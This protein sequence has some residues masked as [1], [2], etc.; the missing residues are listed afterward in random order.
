[1]KARPYKHDGNGTYTPCPPD[2]ATHI[3]LRFPGPFTNRMI[4]VTT[5]DK[6]PDM[7]QWNGQTLTPTL[8]PSIRSRI[9]DAVCHS[10][11]RLGRVEFCA[12]S[13]HGLAG[14][15]IDLLDV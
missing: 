6:L 9:G 3:K 14:Q 2:E 7:W 4:P 1:M 11:V 12:D 5:G 15:T 10:Y 8:S 13:T